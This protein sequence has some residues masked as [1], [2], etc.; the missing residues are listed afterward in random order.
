MENLIKEEFVKM[1]MYLESLKQKDDNLVVNDVI[2]NKSE[3]YDILFIREALIFNENDSDLFIDL[4]NIKTTDDKD[5]KVF[6]F[7]FMDM[8]SKIK[9]SNITTDV[10]SLQS[11]MVDTDDIIRSFDK[12][13]E[14]LKKEWFFEIKL[15]KESE[16]KRK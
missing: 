3:L 15:K 16:R 6:I 10:F 12:E 11:D 8:D 13:I 5:S 14:R 4:N 2:V 7:K 1:G 9:S